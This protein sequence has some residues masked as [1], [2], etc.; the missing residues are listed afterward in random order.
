MLS[1]LLASAAASLCLSLY[2]SAWE[3]EFGP[4]QTLDGKRVAVQGVVLDTPVFQ[5]HRYYYL[6]R[7]EHVT[8]DGALLS[9][10]EVTLRFS[11]S[12]PLSCEPYDTLLCTVQCS[13][14]SDEG[15]YS[16]RNSRFADGVALGGYLID[17]EPVRTVK[18]T[19]LS[20]SELAV[21]VR[22]KIAEQFRAFLPEREAGLVQAMLLGRKEGLPE[23]DVWNFRKIGASHLLVISGLHMAAVAFI[24]CAPFRLFVRNARLRGM[25]SAGAVLGFLCVTGFPPS[26]QRSGLMCLVALWGAAVGRPPDSYNSLGLAVFVICLQNPF[27]GGDLGFT[28]SACSTLGILLGAKRL[29]QLLLSPVKQRPLLR[30]SLLPVANSLSVT[31]S[32]MIFTLPI[33]AAVFGGVSLLSP[34]ANLILIVPCTLVLYLSIPATALGLVPVLEPLTRPLFRL[35]RLLSGTALSLAKDLARLRGGYLDLSRPAGAVVLCLFLCV[36]LIAVSKEPRRVTAA[37]LTVCISLCACDQIEQPN[38]LSVAVAED[39]QCV[40]LL[41]GDS[42]AVLALG[43]YRTGAARELLSRNNVKE[44]D[45]LCFAAAEREEKEAAQA[46]L[47]A[48]PVRRAALPEGRH[49][50]KELRAAGETFS[51][52]DGETL[53][54]LDGVTLQAEQ[55]FG[56]LTVCFGGARIVIESGQGSAPPGSCDLLITEKGAG[57]INS[58]F[59]ILL[60]GD[61]INDVRNVKSGSQVALPKGN[62]LYAVFSEDGICKFGGDSAWL[63]M[64]Q[65]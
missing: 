32:A 16:T 45:L 6:L 53:Q 3:K 59:T 33:Q 9:L 38:S 56:V 5:Y 27:S 51:L 13:S 10:P 60:N 11:T 37:F 35:L 44:V 43:G 1:L 23:S 7:V 58:P 39:S 55:E 17:S 48:Y 63:G 47:D 52:E 64:N 40:V 54:L 22:E 34:L 29:S 28:L 57:E 41:Q 8:E 12:Q 2:S 14:F 18:G 42:A 61:I 49:A 26:A 50:P 46:I 65:T 31:L 62:G 25:L 30:A 19:G 15:L 20:L 24:L 36:L 21:R 4:A